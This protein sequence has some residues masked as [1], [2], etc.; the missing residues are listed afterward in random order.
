M[1]ALKDELHTA[2]ASLN[3]TFRDHLA[4]QGLDSSLIDH[5]SEVNVLLAHIPTI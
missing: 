4:S 2:Y 5:F 3:A 1:D